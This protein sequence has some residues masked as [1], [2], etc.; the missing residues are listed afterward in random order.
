MNGINFD[1]TKRPFWA[2]AKVKGGRIF[3]VVGS[4]ADSPVSVLG[5]GFAPTFDEAREAAYAFLGEYA[6]LYPQASPGWAR[7]PYGQLY[8][9]PEKKLRRPRDASAKRTESRI[10]EYVWT[11]YVGEDDAW[12]GSDPRI[13]AHPILRKTPRKV[14]IENPWN[15]QD[16]TIALDR[17][18]LEREGST[19]SNGARMEFYQTEVMARGGW[20]DKRDARVGWSGFAELGLAGDVGIDDVKAAYRKLALL[21]HPD[22]GGTAEDFTR[23]ET[24][25]REALRIFAA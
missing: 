1:A 2:R 7:G 22:K 18:E 13:T 20:G 9:E 10:Q 8:P 24:A 21:H 4:L 16:G 19:W 12:Y 11:K 5:H 17:A 23:I 3:W 25:Y 15:G 14:F 6:H